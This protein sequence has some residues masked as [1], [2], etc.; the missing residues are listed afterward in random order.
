MLRFI[1]AAFLA[2]L[3]VAPALANAARGFG[4]TVGTA[5][6]DV[7]TTGAIASTANRTFC[8]WFNTS[9]ID[10]VNSVRLLYQENSGAISDISQNT[11]A[12]LRLVIGSSGANS[13]H[14]VAEPSAGSWHH[15]CITYIT[16]T[17]SVDPI[18]YLDGATP[19]VT[20]ITQASGV[21]RTGTT[22][23]LFGNI[24]AGNRGFD[25][26]IA[27]V[28]GWSSI[29]TSGNVASLYNSGAGASANTIGTP[30]FYFKLCGD[31]SPEPDE[32]GGTAA[33]VTGALQTSHPFSNC[34]VN[35]RHD[36]SLVGVGK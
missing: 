8:L 24:T 15:L 3:L 26:S 10:A 34:T 29:L 23:Y 13:S 25:G 31:T 22:A 11:T 6:T 12:N 4:T 5:T 16:S 32:M 14:N 36:G 2:V 35:T 33:T 7:I 30:D 19:A 20:E 17:P 9:T 28:A 21:V 1:A 27:E 18:F